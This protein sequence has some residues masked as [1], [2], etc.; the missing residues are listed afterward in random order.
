MGITN[1]DF[2]DREEQMEDITYYDKKSKP[3][4]VQSINGGEKRI[5]LKITSSS[6]AYGIRFSVMTKGNAVEKPTSITFKT[7][8]VFRPLKTKR[9]ISE[10]LFLD[11]NKKIWTITEV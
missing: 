9:R 2:V 10:S 4:D 5:P 8:K 7:D 6:T 11:E 1:I 3:Q